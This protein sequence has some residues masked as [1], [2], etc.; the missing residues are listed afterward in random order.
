LGNSQEAKIEKSKLWV[1]L[2]TMFGV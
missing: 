1:S 2:K